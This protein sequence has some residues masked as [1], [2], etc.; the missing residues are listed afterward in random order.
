MGSFD[1]QKDGFEK[2]FKGLGICIFA[3]V[4]V[5]AIVEILRQHN[6]IQ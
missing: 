6:L 4:A 5:C 1:P 2:I 3:L